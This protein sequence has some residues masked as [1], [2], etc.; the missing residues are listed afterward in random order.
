M[1]QFF[2]LK[3]PKV[4]VTSVKMAEEGTSKACP[5]TKAVNKLAKT[6]KINFI[7]T[8]KLIKTLHQP[9]KPLLKEKKTKPQLNPGNKTFLFF[10]LL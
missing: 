8:Q 6:I 3:S 10:N 9:G 4:R 2:I 5:F 7:R 1:P